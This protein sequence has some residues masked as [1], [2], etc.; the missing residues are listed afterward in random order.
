[1]PITIRKV[2]IIANLEK[3]DA[4][5]VAEEIRSYLSSQGI[6]VAVFNFRGRPA[7]PRLADYDLAFSL[8]GDGTVLFSARILSYSEIPILAVNLGEFGFIT[9]VQRKEWKNAFEQYRDGMLG[10]GERLMINVSVRRKD[11]EIAQYTGLND[12]V[13]SAGGISK[14]IRLSV[15]LGDSP[16]GRYRADGIIVATPTGST[17]YSAAAGGPILHPEMEAMILNPICPFTL[18]HRPLVVPGNELICIDV[19]E[20]QR[21]EVIL[22]VDGQTMFPLL[23]QDEVEIASA[24]TKARIIR[25][26]IRTFYEVLRSKLNWSGEPNH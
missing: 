10:V 4:G 11:R 19:E 8:G 18:S 2:L 21:A 13:I 1:M 14:L 3:D 7:Q 5:I 6:Q 24:P 20:P 17:A 15:R 12:T 26:D 16:V 23:P 25:S 22:T 9:E